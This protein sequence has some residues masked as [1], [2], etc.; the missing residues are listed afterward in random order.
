MAYIMAA[1]WPLYISPILND[2]ED[3]N[4]REEEYEIP[5]QAQTRLNALFRQTIGS[6]VQ[7][8]YPRL[9]TADAW[10]S[11]IPPENFEIL[12]SQTDRNT[13]IRTHKSGNVAGSDHASS[14]VR[15]PEMARYLLVASY[16]ASFNPTRMDA[17]ILSQTRDPNK[18]FRKLGAR[19]TNV[20]SALKVHPIP[21]HPIFLLSP[22]Y[23]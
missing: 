21:Y 11:Q 17:R 3:H 15:L 10:L 19:K 23:L 5:A 20:S 9:I 1:N 22:F 16:L 14:V 7:Q 8:L 4:N 18:R 13:V 12:L 6:S 2:W